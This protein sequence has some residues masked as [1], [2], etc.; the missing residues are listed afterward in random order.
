MEYILDT[1]E[2]E[3][4]LSIDGPTIASRKNPPKLKRKIRPIFAVK[5][6]VIIPRMLPDDNC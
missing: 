4:S 5:Y 1:E 2:T 6:P 3:V